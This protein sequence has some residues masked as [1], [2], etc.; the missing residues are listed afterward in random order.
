[1]LHNNRDHLFCSVMLDNSNSSDQSSSSGLPA[2]ALRNN[3]QQIAIISKVAQRAQ[4]I[5]NEATTANS[6]PSMGSI[7][8][9]GKGIEDLKSKHD[10]IIDGLK[11]NKRS[12]RDAFGMDD[13]DEDKV[14]VHEIAKSR[15]SAIEWN[16]F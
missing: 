14:K 9:H 4:A 12:V 8:G 7:T 16:Q 13:Y 15:V 3:N 6:I 10:D 1:M 5:T 11:S 2:R